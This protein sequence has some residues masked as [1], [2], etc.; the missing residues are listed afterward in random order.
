M[1]SR[2]AR[3]LWTSSDTQL[4]WQG[5]LADARRKGRK[6]PPKSLPGGWKHFDMLWPASD[7]AYFLMGK[8]WRVSRFYL[9]L[10]SFQSHGQE[11]NG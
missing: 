5:R 6:W 9:W 8:P 3:V 11:W 1:T 7:G 10:G 2:S 4:R